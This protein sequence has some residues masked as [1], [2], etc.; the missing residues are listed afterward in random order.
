MVRR[1]LLVLLFTFVG[2]ALLGL[3]WFTHQWV[4]GTAGTFVYEGEVVGMSYPANGDESHVN[5]AL[6]PAGD[7]SAYAV[8]N[9]GRGAVELGDHATI[10]CIIGPYTLN[11][12]RE[13]SCELI[14]VTR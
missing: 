9:P 6:D 8:A 3:I 5:I 2:A 13:H 10:K 14:A 12:Y 7:Y 1:V 11:Y 4:Q